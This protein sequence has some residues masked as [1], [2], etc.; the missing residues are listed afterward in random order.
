M[1]VLKLSAQSSPDFYEISD[2][3]FNT[4]KTYKLDIF[5]DMTLGVDGVKDYSGENAYIVVG[6]RSLVFKWSDGSINAAKM[7]SG[8]EMLTVDTFNGDIKMPLYRLDIGMA[9]RAIEYKSSG[10]KQI[11]G[12]VY[13]AQIK[14][15]VHTFTFA[16]K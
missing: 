14:K 11:F 8:K 12:Y 4:P 2:T 1:S 6:N 13:N 3:F 7:V 15:Y 9:V 10:I 16:L 5:C